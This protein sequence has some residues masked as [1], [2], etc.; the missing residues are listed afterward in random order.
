LSLT[1]LLSLLLA[2]SPVEGATVATV[3][4]VRISSRELQDR[5][6]GRRQRGEQVGAEAVAQSLVDEVLLAS[7]A[8]RRKLPLPPALAAQLDEARRRAAGR[9]YT[10]TV[11]AGVT[12]DEETLRSVFH[13]N[14]D[15]VRFKLLVVTT[16]EAGEAARDRLKRGGTF[17]QESKNSLHAESARNGGDMGL[18]SRG[19]L[20][21]PLAAV[22]FAA[23]LD[24][25]HGPVALD[26]G[27]AVVQVSS[28][29]IGTEA[30]F[31]QKREKLVVFARQQLAG[32]TRKHLVDQLRAKDKVK[33]DEPFLLSTGSSVDRAQADRV[34]A[35]VSGRPLRYGALLTYI[36]EVF[37]GRPQGHSFGASVKVEMA[38]TMIDD[39]LLEA[40]AVRTGADKLPA[41]EAELAPLRREALATA[42]AQSLRDGALTPTDPELEAWYRA[43]PKEFLQP[44]SRRCRVI[45]VQSVPAASAVRKRLEAGEQFGTVAR[46]VSL[47]ADSAARGGD[48]GE[49]S[50]ATLATMERDPAQAS[51]ARTIRSAPAAALTGPVA[52]G[53]A[54]YLFSCEA[55]RPER[56]VPLAEVRPAVV[57]RVRAEAGQRA[58]DAALARLRVAARISIDREAVLRAAPSP[59]AP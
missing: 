32:A 24:E 58:L 39:Q 59:H 9:H 17:L 5:L 42:L 15:T 26:L 40:E 45:V 31:A 7:E 50:F 11:L 37:Q 13:L 46:E 2:A 4:G 29:T 23:P 19:S 44:A 36:D 27:F 33:L 34:I 55:I 18:R 51:L 35:T 43:H 14:A 52:A 22:V 1:L 56:T 53:G 12:P 8:G 47:D 21:A 48:L 6:A 38:N 49:V 28:R 30:E 57:A 54:Q 16:R 10:D 3:D 20:P 25:I 41:V